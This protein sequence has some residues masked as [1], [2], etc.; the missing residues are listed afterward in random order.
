MTR[1][2]IVGVLALQGAFIE[3]IQYFNQAITLES[4]KYDFKF[5]EVKTKPQLDSCDG[6]VIPGG[7]STS[8]SLIAERTNMLE[9]L[10]EFVKTKPVWGTCAGLIFL[11]KYLIGGK[12][13]QKLLGGIDI[14]VTRNAFGRQLDSFEIDLDFSNF[15]PNCTNFSTF[16][17]RAPVITLIS[18]KS[19]SE[20]CTI[21]SN[22]YINPD[23]VQVLYTLSYKDKD[24][25]V[26][27]KQGLKLGTSFHPELSN[28]DARFHK[29]FLD[30]FVIKSVVEK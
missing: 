16:F 26:A 15:I 13:D 7:E 20:S 12:V 30:E 23:P 28:G 24:L 19:I 11:A 10:M 17:I 21:S 2:I 9:P 22:D 25:I 18:P 8:M 6:L 5:I 29:Y 14:E 27:V 3:H 1:Q 4:Y